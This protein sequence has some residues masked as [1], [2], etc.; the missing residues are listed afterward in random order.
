MKQ[1]IAISMGDF[2]GIGPEVTI[3]A[4][5][6]IDYEKSIP[7]WIGYKPVFDLYSQKLNSKLRITEINNCN[8]AEP[9]SVNILELGFTGDNHSV[10]PGSVEANAGKAAMLAVEKG[11]ECCLTD[12]ADALVTAPIS[13]EAIRLAGYNVPGH[14]EFLAQK[15]DTEQVLMMLVNSGLR[16]ALVTIHEP[17]E[18]VAGL[19]NKNRIIN[20]LIVLNNSLQH[21]FGIDSP[22]IAVL[23]LNPHAGDGGVIGQEEIDI[24][25]PATAEANELG[26]SAEGP[27]PGDGYFGTR[28]NEQFD[29]TLAMYHDQ[30]LI[31]FKTLS[32][33]KGVNFSAGLPIIR[34]SPDH[35]TAFSIAGKNQADEASILA[36]YQLAVTLAENRTH[37]V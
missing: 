29:A 21:D 9:G 27:F 13:K 33:G 15:T 28:L 6:K 25:T 35:G 24:I 2:N 3:K 26:I 1:K 17:L 18:K 19:I 23:G 34:T 16:V 8:E 32:F 14:T 11:I 20:R 37:Q 31:P 36:A 5:Q 12:Q 30:G 4:L 10:N 7:I 22:K